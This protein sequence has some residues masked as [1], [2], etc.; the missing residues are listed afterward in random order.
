MKAPPADRIFCW[1]A[2]LPVPEKEFGAFST[3]TADFLRQLG[4]I[5]ERYEIVPLRE[6]VPGGRRKAADSAT[7]ARPRAALTFD[8]AL[9]CQALFAF[10]VLEA[11]GLPFTLCIPVQSIDSAR[12]LW[13]TQ[14]R[15]SLLKTSARALDLGW[16]SVDLSAP[17]IDRYAV[18]DE[19]QHL[20]LAMTEPEWRA[21]TTSLLEQCADAAAESSENASIRPMSWAQIAA[22][23]PQ[24]CEPASH[25]FLHRPGVAG[26]R[27]EDLLH[28][29]CLSRAEIQNR[30]G[31]SC[32]VYCFPFGIFTAASVAA[33]RGAGYQKLLTTCAVPVGAMAEDLAGRFAGSAVFKL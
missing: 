14:L 21:A 1:H 5:A 18:A 30:L 7:P 31:R 27:P 13:N 33:A 6:L 16:M 12:P 28:D 20:L 9:D 10:P 19:I 22:L 25:S 29:A 17:E 23:S 11:R 2:V 3:S 32:L 4:A 24:L 8:D 26:D 15:L